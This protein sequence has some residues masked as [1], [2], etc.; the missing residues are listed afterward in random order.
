MTRLLIDLPEEVNAKLRARA[1]QA[2][3]ASAEEYIQVLITADALDPGAPSHLTF[4]TDQELEQFLV[5]RLGTED[6]GEMTNGDFDAIRQR[7][8]HTASQRRKS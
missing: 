7:V 4:R 8:R 6:A 5:G 3:Y 1:A 2:G